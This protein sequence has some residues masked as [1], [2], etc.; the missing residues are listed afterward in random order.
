MQ[1]LTSQSEHRSDKADASSTRI[2]DCAAKLFRQ[3]GYASVTLRQIA[4]AAGMKA[5]SVYYHFDSKEVIVSE[6]LNRG[7][8]VVHNEVSQVFKSQPDNAQ[9][10]E[11]IHACIEAHLRSLFT[12]SDYTSANVRIYSQV[13]PH[14]REANRKARRGYEQLWDRILK[15]AN[16]QDA[17]RDDLDNRHARL[18]LI[19]SL[20]ATLEWFDP[21]RGSIKTLSRNYSDLLLK[22]LLK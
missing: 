18:M 6:I 15:R 7:I 17:L 8:A 12:Y 14:V 2:L 10:G 11:V 4:A 20:N 22:G 5:G 16:E 3:Q 13:P 21:K 1:S 19:S 9:A